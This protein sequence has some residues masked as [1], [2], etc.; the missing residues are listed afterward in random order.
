MVPMSKTQLWTPLYLSLFAQISTKQ[1]VKCLVINL[2]EQCCAYNYN[3]YLVQMARKVDLPCFK[4]SNPTF[5]LVILQ[6]FA[7]LEFV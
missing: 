4:A 7:Y 3:K 5:Y 2:F 1:S 6:C